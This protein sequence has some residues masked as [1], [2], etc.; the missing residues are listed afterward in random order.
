[1]DIAKGDD[2]NIRLHPT[3]RNVVFFNLVAHNYFNINCELEY[4][5]FY[6]VY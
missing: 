5:C 1:M 4:P 3:G 2:E 6:L